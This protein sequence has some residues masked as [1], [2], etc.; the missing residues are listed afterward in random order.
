MNLSAPEITPISSPNM[1]PASAAIPAVKAALFRAAVP[2]GCEEAATLIVRIPT[3]A[4]DTGQTS[5]IGRVSSV[6]FGP[7]EAPY[8][9]V[10]RMAEMSEV[11]GC[12]VGSNCTRD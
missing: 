10:E 7:R 2:L 8:I 1:S 6:T 3:A 4:G 11:L 5:N 12:A 9:S